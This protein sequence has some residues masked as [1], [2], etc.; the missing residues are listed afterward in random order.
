MS[1][2]RNEA[3][4]LSGNQYFTWHALPRFQPRF[5]VPLDFRR[6]AGGSTETKPPADRPAADD[7]ADGAAAAQPPAQ[8]PPMPRHRQIRVVRIPPQQPVL[9]MLRQTA[10]SA[11]PISPANC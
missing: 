2:S 10:Q 11:S 1:A 5:S 6:L 3:R 7:P 4:G 9:K 8:P